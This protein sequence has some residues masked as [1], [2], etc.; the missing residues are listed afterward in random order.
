MAE[1]M[2][3]KFI[4]LVNIDDINVLHDRFVNVTV[5]FKFFVIPFNCFFADLS[6]VVVV[7]YSDSPFSPLRLLLLRSHSV[8]LPLLAKDW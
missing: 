3:F 7:K 2:L 4:L 8:S 5:N 1:F 6:I